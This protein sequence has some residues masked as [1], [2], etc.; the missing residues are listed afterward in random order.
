MEN[1][2]ET[3]G[4]QWRPVVGYEGLYSISN[5]GRLRR[6]TATCAHPAGHIL[7]GFKNTL[8]YWKYAVCRDGKERCL[9]AHRV[10]AEAW[11]GPAPTPKH[12]VNHKDGNKANIELSNL[13]WMT[14]KENHEH[15]I[16]VLGVKPW[17][18]PPRGDA[19]YNVKLTADAI[20]DI[21]AR[22]GNGRYGGPTQDDLA[23]QHGV[24]RMTICRVLADTARA[25]PRHGDASFPLRWT[26]AQAKAISDSHVGILEAQHTP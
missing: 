13:E 17:S 3:T 8:G 26:A 18:N 19:H 6:D 22:A 4:E 10:I 11:I 24:S 9:L 2:V 5:L 23:R 1:R 7:R 20:A 21:Q 12:E 14:R 25:K 16:K 15:A